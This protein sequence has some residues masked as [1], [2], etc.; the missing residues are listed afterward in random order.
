V[1]NEEGSEGDSLS[2]LL[3]ELFVGAA[4]KDGDDNENQSTKYQGRDI[5]DPPCAWSPSNEEDEEEEE[6]GGGV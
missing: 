3:L 2:A 1:T 6:S 5:D 4:T